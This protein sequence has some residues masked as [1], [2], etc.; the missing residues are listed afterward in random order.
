MHS[1]ITTG[2]LPMLIVLPISTVQAEAYPS[3]YSPLPSGPT[4]ITHATILTGTGERLDDASLLIS[5]RQN[6]VRGRR[7]RAR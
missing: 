7:R 4:L 6:C 1:Q 5:G 3:T 2:L